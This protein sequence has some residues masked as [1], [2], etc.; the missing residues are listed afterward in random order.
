MLLFAVGG[1]VAYGLW[2]VS[3]ITKDDVAGDPNYYVVRQAAYALIG[4]A[5]MVGMTLIDP[6]FWRKHY[7]LVYGLLI[8]HARADPDP[9]D[10]RPEHAPLDR[11]R[12]V[13]LPALR[14]REAAA[15]P[16][17]RRVPRRAR[18]ADLRAADDD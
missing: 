16:V 5:G 7:R 13:P 10:E 3:G 15:R 9:R 11:H 17:P 4:L 18:Q 8:V 1:I 12:R 6:G 14:V 2:V